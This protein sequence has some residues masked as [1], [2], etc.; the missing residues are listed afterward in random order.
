MTPARLSTA[1]PGWDLGGPPT[2]LAADA[3]QPMSMVLHELATNAAK[4]GALSTP[5]GAVELSW[6]VG[7]ELGLRFA[8]T[9]RGGPTVAS[10]PGRRGF[11][12]KLIEAVARRQLGGHV[13]LAWEPEGLRCTL[14]PRRAASPAR[15]IWLTRHCHAK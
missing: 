1:G 15:G 3:V 12:S 10:P 11:G 8:W 13:E 4:Y 7:P 5:E 9:E 6:A 2:Q 14:R